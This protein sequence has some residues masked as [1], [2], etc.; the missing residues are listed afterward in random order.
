MV[1]CILNITFRLHDFG[2]ASDGGWSSQFWT[3]SDFLRW[4]ALKLDRFNRTYQQIC[5]TSS[6]YLKRWK[7]SFLEDCWKQINKIGSGAGSGG[8]NQC[9][10]PDIIIYLFSDPKLTSDPGFGLLIK[11]VLHFTL[12]VLKAQRILH[13]HKNCRSS[14]FCT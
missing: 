9:C 6:Q 3:A 4:A 8:E 1:K 5:S 14:Q 11:K 13:P 7:V 10:G 12:F 2:V